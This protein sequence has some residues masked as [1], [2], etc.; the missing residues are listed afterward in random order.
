MRFLVDR[1]AGRKL[2][3]W[4][5]A[6]GHDVVESRERGADPGDRT[7]IEWA[8]REGRILI[9]LDTDFGAFL[10]LEALPHCGLV[11]L[12]DVPS[13]TRIRYVHEILERHSHALANGAVITVKRG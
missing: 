3:E 9:T 6:N 12:P 5:R 7:L 11:R 13:T 1:C 4:L 2:A 8:A 10:F